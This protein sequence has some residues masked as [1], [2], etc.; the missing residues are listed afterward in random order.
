M[1]ETH[2]LAS[3]VREDVFEVYSV[4]PHRHNIPFWLRLPAPKMTQSGRVAMLGEPAGHGVPRL[5]LHRTIVLMPMCTHIPLASGRNR[6]HQ[7]VFFQP[8]PQ[9][10]DGQLIDIIDPHVEMAANKLCPAM[11]AILLTD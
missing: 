7:R 3:E 6:T 11:G 10:V 1:L 4:P 2:Y 5:R 9:G 8:T